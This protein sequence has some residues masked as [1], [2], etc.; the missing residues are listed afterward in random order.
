M[1]LVKLQVENFKCVENSTEFDVDQVTY[2]IGKN[3]SGKTALL[4]A[5]YKLN[6][7]E[8]D[9]SDFN[10]EEFPRRHLATYKDRKEREPANVLTTTW[11][12]EAKDLAA[13]NALAGVK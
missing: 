8:E 2:L 3:E 12:L 10:E 11:Q 4:E 7:V 6:P 13:L 5:L 9:K 1:K